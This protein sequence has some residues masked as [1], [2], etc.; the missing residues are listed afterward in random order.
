MNDSLER[1][2]RCPFYGFSADF[3]GAL[4]SSGG[5]QCALKEGFSPCQMEKEGLSVDWD[6][7]AINNWENVDFLRRVRNRV[8]RVISRRQK[9]LSFEDHWRE[10]MGSSISI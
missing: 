6:H 1:V 3:P 8:Q 7:C 4:C 5:N 10:I 9:T 2:H